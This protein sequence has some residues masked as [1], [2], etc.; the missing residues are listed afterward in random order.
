MT[1]T[2]VQLID[3]QYVQSD[4]DAWRWET[5]GRHVLRLETRAIRQE[6][7]ADFERIHGKRDA[8]KLREKMMQI[9]DAETVPA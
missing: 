2:L 1:A 6:W 7:L 8:D 4:A 3:G 9:H 5:L